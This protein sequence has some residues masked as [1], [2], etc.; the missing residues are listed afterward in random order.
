MQDASHN[1]DCSLLLNLIGVLEEELRS[2]N[3]VI[4]KT[5]GLGRVGGATRM[6]I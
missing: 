3:A 6:S 1:L 2:L 5:L 4:C